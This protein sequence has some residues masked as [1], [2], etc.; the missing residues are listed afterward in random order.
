MEQFQVRSSASNIW[1]PVFKKMTQIWL[2]L[3]CLKQMESKFSTICLLCRQ[4]ISTQRTF[5]AQRNSKGKITHSCVRWQ[6]IWYSPIRWV[7]RLL[8]VNSLR[9]WSRPKTN[10]QTMQTKQIKTL[11]RTTTTRTSNQAYLLATSNLAPTP[12]PCSLL[13][14]PKRMPPY[15]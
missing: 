10:L 8:F 13:R 3:T 12:P 5:C 4:T 9:T 14:A 11:L 7:L 1:R 2:N 6:G 15:L